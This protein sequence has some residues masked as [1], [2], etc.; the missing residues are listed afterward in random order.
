MPKGSQ[1]RKSDSPVQYIEPLAGD[2]IHELLWKVLTL[3]QIQFRG[4]LD[5]IQPLPPHRVRIRV[6]VTIEEDEE[7]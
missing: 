5:L 3:A 1:R 2:H 6:L 7:L 4:L